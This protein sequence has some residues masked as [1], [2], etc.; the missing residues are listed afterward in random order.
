MR[1]MRTPKDQGLFY[2]IFLGLSIPA[3]VLFWIFIPVVSPHLHDDEEGGAHMIRGLNRMQTI[4]QAEH[5]LQQ[6][7]EKLTQLEEEA[8]EKLKEEEKEEK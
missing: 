5:I 4:D 6:A 2:T 7:G 3:V 8:E 1:A